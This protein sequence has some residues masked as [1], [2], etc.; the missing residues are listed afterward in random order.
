MLLATEWPLWHILMEEKCNIFL[1]RRVG[2]HLQ[3]LWI[4][5]ILQSHHPWRHPLRCSHPMLLEFSSPD[6]TLDIADSIH[7]FKCIC[8]VT[9]RFSV[10]CLA[11]CFCTRGDK[12]L[13]DNQRHP[14]LEIYYLLT[15]PSFSLSLSRTNQPTLV[16]A[17]Q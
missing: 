5:S 1:L 3:A 9:I 2:L 7:E 4:Q 16:L 11:V 12:I 6:F 14:L 10:C 13:V 8:F 17:M 15:D